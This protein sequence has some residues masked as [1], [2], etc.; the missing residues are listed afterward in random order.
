MLNSTDVSLRR[1]FLRLIDVTLF[2]LTRTI[3]A[4]GDTS[5][6]NEIDRGAKVCVHVCKVKA[7]SKRPVHTVHCLA[8]GWKMRHRKESLHYFIYFEFKH[9]TVRWSQI[10]HG[11]I[12][13]SD[14][15]R[16]VKLNNNVYY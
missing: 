16:D 15:K 13:G 14:I 12:C 11:G 6:I 5:L 1:I 2:C 8:A 3:L 7:R 4:F 10:S 9:E